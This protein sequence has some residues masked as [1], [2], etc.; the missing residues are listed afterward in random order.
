MPHQHHR[1]VAIALGP[2]DICHDIIPLT[3]IIDGLLHDELRWIRF[4]IWMIFYYIVDGFSSRFFPVSIDLTFDS[5]EF[6]VMLRISSRQSSLFIFSFIYYAPHYFL[7]ILP[8]A[9]IL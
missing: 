6:F 3:L 7:K 2:F 8:S 1:P 5:Y 4:K 9:F